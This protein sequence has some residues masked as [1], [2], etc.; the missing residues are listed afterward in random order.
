[1]NTNILYNLYAFCAKESKVDIAT[2]GMAK[3]RQVN[4]G[5]ISDSDSRVIREFIGKHGQALAK[6]FPD[7]KKFADTVAEAIASDKT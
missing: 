5:V 6:A 4:P 3:F 7:Q 1:M 2:V